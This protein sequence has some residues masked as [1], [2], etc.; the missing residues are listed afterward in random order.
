MAPRS[1]TAAVLVTPLGALSVVIC[2]ILSHFF[3]KVCLF[4]LARKSPLLIVETPR[5]KP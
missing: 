1:F 2:A 3:L 4:D 5:R